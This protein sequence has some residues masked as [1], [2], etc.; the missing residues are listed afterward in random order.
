MEICRKLWVPLVLVLAAISLASTND[1]LRCNKVYNDNYYYGQTCTLISKVIDADTNWDA[2]SDD[3]LVK[4]D[5]IKTV[6]FENSRIIYIPPQ[7]FTKF[8]N[9]ERIYLNGTALETITTD[10]F[11]AARTVKEIYLSQNELRSIGAAVFSKAKTC[12][13]LDL[14]SNKIES[15]DDEAFVGLSQLRQLYLNS[16][17][18][19]SLSSVVFSPLISVNIL[20]LSDNNIESFGDAVFSSARNLQNLSLAVNSLKV[21]S[22]DLRDNILLITIDAS[23]NV[24][25][26]ASIQ[27]RNDSKPL[28]IFVSH[29]QW[30][31][32]T[33]NAT[34]EELERSQIHLKP[35]PNQPA[36]SQSHI[37]NIEC[38]DSNSSSFF[39]FDSAKINWPI[40][41]FVIGAAAVF[42]IGTLIIIVCCRR[43][44]QGFWSSTQE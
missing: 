27:R 44:R 15:L 38:H 3:P 29:N 35:K 8:R 26:G 40:V 7:L 16:N 28:T 34:I 33:L 11:Q 23:S 2:F 14:S 13:K 39:N 41:G 17:R 24:I 6:I 31:C 43:R 20:D 36:V 18:L 32:D 21:L 30:Q 5:Q 25:E 12:Y 1:A 10:S 22:L 19:T 37:Y 4:T 42:I 9:V